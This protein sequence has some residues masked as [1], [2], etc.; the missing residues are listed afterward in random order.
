VLA[1]AIVFAI[2]ALF[3]I[4][5]S[6][7]QDPVEGIDRLR[8]DQA[9]FTE[10]DGPAQSWF[11]SAAEQTA[12]MHLLQNLRP[13]VAIEIGTRLGGS[14]RA[15]ARFSKQVYSLDIDPTVPERLGG[16]YD[17]VEYITGDSSKTLPALLSS[18]QSTGAE[19]GFILVDGDHSAEGV[20]K[21]L[22]AILAFVP[23]VP[24]YI[25]MHD[26]MHP[27]CRAG[28]QA[29]SWEKCPYV[30]EV[31]LDYIPG[32]LNAEAS[33]YRQLWG[34]L[35]LTRMMPQPR[36]GALKMTAAAELSFRTLLPTH[37]KT[38][39]WRKKKDQLRY[40]LGRVFGKSRG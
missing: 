5:T 38:L 13:K 4:T 16:L 34:G 1:N 40:H 39:F 9:P 7:K 26:S 8:I 3:M 23:T 20:R 21:D 30:H 19:L 33:F 17:N 15:I 24:L 32:G 14:L 28:I 18:L 10:F 22:D 25:V 36:E 11:M 12:L 35:S 2:I 27:A 6:P 37:Q 29:A 31:Q